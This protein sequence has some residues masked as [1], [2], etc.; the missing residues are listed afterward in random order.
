[1]LKVFRWEARGR[2]VL[3]LLYRWT[4]I[5]GQLRSTT[6]QLC[7]I[8]LAT[9]E[10]HSCKNIVA[11]ILRER[12]RACNHTKSIIK[13][14]NWSKINKEYLVIRLKKVSSK[15]SRLVNCKVLQLLIDQ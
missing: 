3:L 12:L 14:E 9:I 10:P 11:Q 7:S 4:M 1:M 13:K 5:Q 15:L 8:A 6:L 2:Q